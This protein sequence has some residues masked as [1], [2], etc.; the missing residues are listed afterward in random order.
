M[1][2]KGT[3]FAAPLCS[4]G[5]LESTIRQCLSSS[6]LL[7]YEKGASLRFGSVPVTRLRPC[8]WHIK[9][10]L[11][12]VLT[13]CFTSAC[14][15]LCSGRNLWCYR[16]QNFLVIHGVCAGNLPGDFTSSAMTCTEFHTG[17]TRILY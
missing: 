6:M 2:N 1:P 7:T 16:V 17:H 3:R 11:V 8:F 4:A 10:A 15:Q 9:G 14:T 5:L 13:V 12:L